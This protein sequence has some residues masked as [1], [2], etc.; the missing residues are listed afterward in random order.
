MDPHFSH[1][2]FTC[3]LYLQDMFFVVE[4]LH[5]KTFNQFLKMLKNC[6]TIDLF[7]KMLQKLECKQEWLLQFYVALTFSNSIS[8]PKLYF[9]NI[10]NSTFLF[11][12]CLHFRLRYGLKASSL[13]F[14]WN[15]YLFVM[16]L[17]MQTMQ[18]EDFLLLHS[19]VS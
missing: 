15:S 2:D 16:T 8:P 17:K 4:K 19:I 11:S 9:W 7:W 1:S 3:I 18:L 10:W 14:C 12:F 5:F 6:G 13:S